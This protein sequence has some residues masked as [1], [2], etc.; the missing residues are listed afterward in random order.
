[1]VHRCQAGLLQPAALSVIARPIF[2]GRIIDKQIPRNRLWFRCESVAKLAAWTLVAAC[3]AISCQTAAGQTPRLGI[4]AKGQPGAEAL[5]DLLTARLSP[6]DSIE[7]VERNDMQA[8]V[9]EVN[10]ATLLGADAHQRRLKLGQ[11]IRADFLA[12]L[13]VV[14]AR[15]ADGKPGPA[16]YVR[17]IISDCAYGAR[18]RIEYFPFETAAI[19][20]ICD[21]CARVIR[22]SLRHFDQGI[23]YLIGVPSFVSRNLTREHDSFQEAYASLVQ[24]A[25]LQTPGVAVLELVEARA[26]ADE[27][28]RRGGERE[29][30]AVPLFIRGE[31]ETNGQGRDVSV[32]L[33]IEVRSGDAESRTIERQMPLPEAPDFLRSE[34]VDQILP[35]ATAKRRAL[36]RNEQIRWIAE[37]A[38]TF[39]R[40][41]SL[42]QA[43]ALRETALLLDPDDAGQRLALL[44]ECHQHYLS[45][46]WEAPVRVEL[47]NEPQEVLRRRL[48]EVHLD[49]WERRMRH[50]EYLLHHRQVNPREAGYLIASTTD[51]WLHVRRVRHG[52]FQLSPCPDDQPRAEAFF[53]RTAPMIPGLDYNV[54]RGV[55][56]RGFEHHFKSREPHD[57]DWQPA[58]QNGDWLAVT[59]RS[60][61]EFRHAK[62][63]EGE[64]DSAIL[65][66]L[67]RLLTEVA[68][69]DAF[70]GGLF[71]VREGR[72]ESARRFYQ[73]LI[74]SGHPG[75]VLSGR[76]SL[77]KWGVFFDDD[78]DRRPARLGEARSLIQEIQKLPPSDLASGFLGGTRGFARKL[79]NRMKGIPDWTPPR[80]VRPE[81][82][83]ND[84]NRHHR[85]SFERLPHVTAS[86]SHLINC[87]NRFDLVWSDRSVCVVT[88][89]GNVQTVYQ[90]RKVH[91][92]APDVLQ[93]QWDGR[94]IWVATNDAGRILA[95][96]PDGTLAAEFDAAAGLP[97]SSYY[98]SR[99]GALYPPLQIHAI[100][101][102]RL[103]AA[104]RF[105]STNGRGWFAE[106]VAGN[107]EPRVHVFH[108]QTKLPRS[109]KDQTDDPEFIAPI[110][111]LIEWPGV[112]GGERRLLAVRAGDQGLG[113]DRPPLLVTLPTLDVSLAPVPFHVPGL[114]AYRHYQRLRILKNGQV[115]E[116]VPAGIVSFP[117]ATGQSPYGSRRLM[118]RTRGPCRHPHLLGYRGEV[119]YAGREWYRIDPSTMQVEP[120]TD[121]SLPSDLDFKHYAVSAHF[122][123]V[124]WNQDEPL[125]RV[126]LVGGPLGKDERGSEARP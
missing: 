48:Q 108:K 87:S 28:Q 68:P 77:L 59:G 82:N 104:G 56:R 98:G 73:R 99:Y 109:G 29:S 118:F 36:S 89:D 11:Q 116:A 18:L 19:Q 55:I 63:R 84:R 3:L 34:V 51:Y 38:E 62:P 107:A 5:A 93:C 39:S 115:L 76:Y 31:F 45:G 124:A 43:I 54:A 50:V 14:D 75:A 40:L 46:R 105:G 74:E 17:L 83:G 66:Q 120:L 71:P 119:L 86:W 94:F 44:A 67:Y 69:R 90:P 12:W 117:M 42:Q 30:A 47:R 64:L 65:D 2:G 112:E 33:C 126:R 1:M 13:S 106:L 61:V 22:Q 101:P 88:G 122:G 57:E 24:A 96:E 121:G 20:E 27:L 123:L 9:R 70:T 81:A 60:L 6:E 80:V 53:W 103:L 35:L 52:V 16:A 72:S 10:M 21:H 78:P 79:E 7:L 85:L 91:R 25:L 37:R 8:V 95:L 49:W 114:N 58:E 102:G 15:A 97:P 23:R 125:H 111:A 41:G 4:I 26:I 113:S 110:S 92:D 32:R 100:A